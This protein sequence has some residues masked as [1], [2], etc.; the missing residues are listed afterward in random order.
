[1]RISKDEINMKITGIIKDAFLF[2][3]KNTGRFSTYLLLSVLMTGFAFGGLLTNAFGIIDAENYLYGGI[4]FIIVMIIGFIISGYHIKI[5]K[6]GIELDEEVPTFKLF[7]DFMTGFD[8]VMVS[9]FYFIIPAL[10]VLLVG[11]DTNTFNNATAL[12]KAFVSQ[13]YNVYI[14]GNST[15]IAVNALSHTVSNFIN[16]LT[17]TL[18]VAFIIFLIFS[19]LQSVGEARLANTGSLREALNIFEAAK[20]IKRIGVGKAIILLLLIVVIMGAIEII[21]INILQY[22]PFLLSIIYIILTPYMVLVTQ[23]AIGLA[24]SDIA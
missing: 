3:S 10:I 20:D 12:G 8:N 15:D 23:R 13:I 2:P 16:S 4:Y 19:M 22:Y 1:M 6:S 7:E 18:T 21:F 17:I 11:Y 9:L 24:Y 5:I 14:M